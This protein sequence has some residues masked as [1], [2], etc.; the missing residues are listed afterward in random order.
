MTPIESLKAN[1][2]LFIAKIVVLIGALNWL[3][4]GLQ[5][6]NYILQYT[7]SNAK[8]IYILAGAAGIYLTYLEIMMYKNQEN[9]TVDELMKNY[10]KSN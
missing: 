6:T 1:P 2:V 4:I 7:G 3:A 8:Y 9:L 5:N 10:G